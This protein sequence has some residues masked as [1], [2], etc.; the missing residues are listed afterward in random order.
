M[1]WKVR[2]KNPAFWTGLIGVIGTFAVGVAQLLGFD[3]ASQAE[4]WQTA[5]AAL[6]VA[7]FGVLGVAGVAVDPTTKGM[8]DSAQALTYEEPKED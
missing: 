7:V 1:N 8:T 5:L 4:G 2:L 3:I 6:V